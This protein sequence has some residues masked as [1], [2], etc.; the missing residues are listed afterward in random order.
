MATEDLKQGWNSADDVAIVVAT[1]TVA[2][3]KH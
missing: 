3:L 1:I 2:I